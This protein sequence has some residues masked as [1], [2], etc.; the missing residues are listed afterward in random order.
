MPT[1]GTSTICKKKQSDC[2]S[3]TFHHAIA[4]ICKK[5]KVPDI[6]EGTVIRSPLG[7]L[8]KIRGFTRL[9]E[10]HLMLRGEA[11]LPTDVL[12]LLTEEARLEYG[13]VKDGALHW[14]QLGWQVVTMPG[15][16]PT[17]DVRYCTTLHIPP[18][19]HANLIVNRE[20]DGHS[21][22]FSRRFGRLSKEYKSDGTTRK[23]STDEYYQLITMS[24][25][26][27]LQPNDES[28]PRADRFPHDSG[29]SSSCTRI[30]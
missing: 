26:N 18:P 22:L 11:T 7:K 4:Y 10:Y 16:E 23:I 9:N 15:T 28:S 2:K 19:M 3:A 5:D 27:E 29:R 25:Y 24:E 6:E 21:L 12:L 17:Q 30:I 1:L 20:S 13:L 14:P 8:Y